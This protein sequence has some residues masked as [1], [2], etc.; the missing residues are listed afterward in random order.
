MRVY[1]AGPFF[2]EAQK[3][4]VRKVESL[5]GVYGIPFFSPMHEGVLVDMDPVQKA[6]ALDRIFAKNVEELDACSAVVAIVD[7]RDTGTVWE[8]GYSY[9]LK[10]FF[11]PTRRGI[12][13]IMTF[14]QEGYGLNVMI[15]KC[16]D[17]H[18]RSWDE[19]DSVVSH[20]SHGDD[21]KLA[22]FRNFS[23]AV[24]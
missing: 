5:L 3:Q 6:M 21:K 13:T 19:L 15:Q 18:A 17:A 20:Y 10:G 9:C 1:L 11:R 22:Q 24:T 23:P 2:T 4:V 14:S 12:P 7:G 8:L 16:V